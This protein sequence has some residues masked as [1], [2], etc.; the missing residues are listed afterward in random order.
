M[1]SNTRQ[2]RVERALTSAN[3]SKCFASAVLISPIEEPLAWTNN[4]RIAATM[5]FFSS[6]VAVSNAREGIRWKAA[7][8]RRLMDD[9]ASV[10]SMDA[11][12]PASSKY[13]VVMG[14]PVDPAREDFSS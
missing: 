13:E 11:A 12:V 10:P 4:S 7:K 14:K 1:E 2:Q 6:S 3:L 9:E 8:S 5:I